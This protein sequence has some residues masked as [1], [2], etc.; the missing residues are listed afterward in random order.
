[1]Y[2]AHCRNDLA[3]SVQLIPAELH[4]LIKALEAK[5]ERA[6][7]QAEVDFADYLL[8]RVAELREAAR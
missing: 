7:E 1:L 2:P 4:E 5:A 6:I 8:A 3:I